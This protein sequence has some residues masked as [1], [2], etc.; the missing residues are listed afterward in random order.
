MNR[1][2]NISLILLL[3]ISAALTIFLRWRALHLE[4]DL[5]ARLRQQQ[6]YLSEA[7][8]RHA[9]LLQTLTDQASQYEN[10]NRILA[11]LRGEVSQLRKTSA[12]PATLRAALTALQEEAEKNR[13]AKELT[14]PPDPAIVRAHWSREQL[15]FSGYADGISAVQSSLWALTQGD[16]ATIAAT[17]TPELLKE[18]WQLSKQNPTDADKAGTSPEAV[19]AINS[20][21]QQL[22]ES[23]GPA[24]GFSLVSDNLVPRMPDYDANY[25]IFRIYFEGEGA[26]RA[27]ML[28]K[29]GD[30][31]KFHG[32]HVLG[33]TEEKPTY[34]QTL[35]P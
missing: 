17:F 35:W 26:T 13:L 27:I 11:R 24:T 8:H 22:A 4:A 16:S 30:E 33:G 28:K 12:D 15:A 3:A 5:Q 23:L 25:Q 9:C 21:F 7:T 1:K 6:N 18:L 19:V 32:I 20:K 14:S 34:E 29:S 2:T 10:V 31:W